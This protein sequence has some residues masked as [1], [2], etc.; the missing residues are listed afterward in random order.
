M[1]KRI[2]VIV[3]STESSDSGID[4]YWDHELT[5]EEQHGY[6]LKEYPCDYD[7]DGDCCISWEMVELKGKKRPL[8]LEKSEWSDQI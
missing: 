4:G 5:L 7:V 1:K 8:L 6:M 2:Y 3:W